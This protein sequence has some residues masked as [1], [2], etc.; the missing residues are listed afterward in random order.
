MKSDTARVMA[1]SDIIATML[2]RGPKPFGVFIEILRKP[3]KNPDTV[4]NRALSHYGII[5]SKFLIFFICATPMRL[6][7]HVPFLWKW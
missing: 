5:I 1:K 6:R 7:K 2:S 4:V 3:N